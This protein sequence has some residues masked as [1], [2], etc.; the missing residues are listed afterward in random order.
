MRHEIVD[1]RHRAQIVLV[2]LIDDRTINRGRDLGDGAVPVVHPD[3]YDVHF[4]GG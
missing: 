1:V 4:L 3:F 2:R